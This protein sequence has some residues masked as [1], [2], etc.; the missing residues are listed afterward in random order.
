MNG[1]EHTRSFWTHERLDFSA[2]MLRDDTSTDVCIV[3]GGIA[4]LTT[5]Y[6]LSRENINVV[7]IDA[8]APGSGE[9][10]RTTAHLSSVID[11]R[12]YNLERWHGAASARLAAESHAAAIS[13]IERIVGEEAIDC[14]FR[15]LDGFLF[16]P[17]A[18]GLRLLE[19]ELEAARRAGLSGTRLEDCP[20]ELRL[21][22]NKCLRFP[23]Q[24]QFHPLRYLQG[25]LAA[26]QRQEGR[27]FGATRAT[28]IREST[29]VV[30]STENGSRIRAK[31]L[32]VATNSPI[33]NRVSLHAKMAPYRT[34]VVAAEV[35]ADSVPPGLYWDNLNPYHY[36]RL[37]E[38]RGTLDTLIVG[39]EDHKTGQEAD[40]D[41]R[42]RVLEAWARQRF[43]QCGK[44]TDRWSGQVMETI[45]GLGFI[46]R[47]P[48]GPENSFVITG[49]SGMGMTHGTL[50]AALVTD[51]I[52]GRPNRWEALYDPARKP[53]SAGIN[54]AEENFNV[55]RQ[56]LD[57]GRPS[58][59]D[60]LA[61]LPA[62]CGRVIQRGLQKLA[63]YR[64]S[65]G[66]LHEMSA[67]CR[68]LGCIVRWNDTEHTWDCPCHGSRYEAEGEVINGPAIS[69]LS[70]H[71]SAPTESSYGKEP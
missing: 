43:P 5:A 2:P 55:A 47:A 8:T 54:F 70:P 41:L 28:E 38:R 27:V 24:A 37:G 31:Y 29:E 23:N 67:V 21:D 45:D 46:G 59:P 20:R 25:L 56:Y 35:P 19:E 40:T 33:N 57:W 42:F 65:D 26:I 68:H 1:S 30:V 34:Y 18:D 3:G 51:L 32:V 60:D 49:D 39:G 63:V 10:S 22:G 52:Q 66:S 48:G 58:A 9:T 44:I 7:V 36:A 16:T 69:A 50:G 71:V 61:D 6:L 13:L 17:Q 4:G 11:D 62:N 15:R 14:E 53:L 12:F 64:A